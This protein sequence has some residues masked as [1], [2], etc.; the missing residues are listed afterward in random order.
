MFDD[1]LARWGL[2]PDGAPIATR[3][4]DL[5][6]VRRAGVPAMLKIA[7]EAE[8]RWGGLLMSWWGGDGAARVLAQEGDALLLERATG[9]GSL[10]EMARGGRDDEASRIICA[11]A[12]RL[13]APRGCPPPELIPLPRWFAALEPAA[14]RHG[15]ILSLAAATARELLAEPQ[16]VVVLHGDI[17]HGNVL[18]FGPRGWLAI[19]PKRLAGE[20]GFD[21]ANLFCNPDLADRDGAR[22]SGATGDRGGR[23]RGSRP[24]AAAEVDL[25]V[26]R[27]VGRVVFGGREAGRAPAC[28][29]VARCGGARLRQ[30]S[31]GQAA[32]AQDRGRLQRRDAND[33]TAQPFA[34]RAMARRCRTRPGRT[35]ARRCTCGPRSSARSGWPRRRGST[36]RG[37]SPSM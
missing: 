14:A 20:R 33:A 36:I 16:E 9:K 32:M 12:A 4:S 34:D 10:V 23:R 15:G 5:L 31:G 1:Y 6:P 3:S 29:G 24:L 25:G 28:D 8:E 35:A 17:H 37:T 13:H 26:G 7:R 30:N 21:F 18:D 22:A 2:T 11:V 19:D 27:P